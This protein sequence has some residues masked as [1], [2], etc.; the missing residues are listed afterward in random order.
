[1]TNSGPIDVAMLGPLR[2][3][4][5]DG[6]DVLSEEWRTSKTR[7]LLRLLALAEPQPVRVS[8]LLE[9]LWPDA[10]EH[11]ARNRL[12]T[13]ASQIRRTLRDSTCLVR[14]SD[15]L[16]LHH[17]RVDVATF[18]TMAQRADL[19]SRIGAS[20]EVLDCARSAQ[21]LY[22]GDFHADDDESS[23]AVGE[24][25]HLQKVHRDLL[26][27]AAV[28]ALD[29]GLFREALALASGTLHLD[30]TSET[31]H[32]VVMQAHAELGE[33]ATALRVFET[34]RSHLAEELGVDPSPQTLALHLR[35]LQGYAPDTATSVQR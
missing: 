35:L 2:V 22:R 1:M 29:L 30:P 28:A 15:S 13:A 8:T 16:R 32:R 3:R 20:S 21:T 33:V 4:R 25:S 9:K 12:R 26:C 17:V 14:E 18:R 5:A 24:R 27:D 6:S 7:D 31:A 11:A 34:Y 23:W 10:T 19:A